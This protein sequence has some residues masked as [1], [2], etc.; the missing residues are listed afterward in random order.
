MPGDCKA[1][2]DEGSSRGREK[3]VS[4]DGELVGTAAERDP[5]T[6]HQRAGGRY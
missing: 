6:H 4:Q 2:S 5:E 1:E 3:K